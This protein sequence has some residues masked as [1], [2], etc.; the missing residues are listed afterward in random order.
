MNDLHSWLASQHP[1]LR[2]FK[3]FQ[4]KLGN[5]AAAHPQQRAACMLLSGIVGRYIEEFDEAPLPSPVA[6]RAY[7]RLLHAV[8]A[9]KPSADATEQLTRLNQLAELRLTP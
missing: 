2:T 8:A 7:S 1:G 9:L 6:D 4:Q 3:T 5:V